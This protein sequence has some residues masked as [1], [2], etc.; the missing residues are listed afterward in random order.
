MLLGV[1][2]KSVFQRV[3]QAE[4]DEPTVGEEAD[5]H[6]VY[7]SRLVK[8]IT[9]S[10]PVLCDL[11]EA[12]FG[13]DAYSGPIMCDPYRAPELILDMTWKYPVDIWSLG[14]MV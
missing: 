4:I 13:G 11:T 8:E 1:E 7:R 5:D 3:E 10:C 6:V 14:M 12:V 2:D 9:G